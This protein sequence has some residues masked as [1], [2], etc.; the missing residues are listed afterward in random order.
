MRD[1]PTR[2]LLLLGVSGLAI[3]PVGLAL[4]SRLRSA[5]PLSVG[6]FVDI[7]R[8][9][10]PAA[11]RQL[12]TSGYDVTG[13]GGAIYVPD[14]DQR[15]QEASSWRVRDPAGRW[16]VL[17]E[18]Q[19]T[20]E[21]FGARGRS[22]DASRDR[23][24]MQAA[25]LFASRLG[26]P[27]VHAA[28]Q[29]TYETDGEV[30][31]GRGVA[32]ILNG[33]TVRAV[34][35]HPDHAALSVLSDSSWKQGRVTVVSTGVP[36]AQAGCHA[37]VR[38]GPV[39]GASSS[40]AAVDP[41][42][43]VSGWL[44]EDLVIETDAWS[45]ETRA[46]KVAVQI[47]GGASGWTVR[48]V[49]APDSTRMWGLIH[50]DWASVGPV[51]SAD[52]RQGPNRAAYQARPRRG[53]TTHPRNGLIEDCHGGRFTARVTGTDTG[54]DGIRLSACHDITVRGCTMKATTYAGLRIVGGD[55]GFEFAD[56]ASRAR[57]HKGLVVEGFEV[58]DARGGYACWVD[59]KA[60]NV[61]RAVR[62][63]GYVPMVPT[64]PETDLLVS[65]L[66]G[67]TSSGAT[68]G[69]RLNNMRG[70]EFA[71]C[72][73]QGFTDGVQVDEGVHDVR[74]TRPVTLDSH[75]HGGVVDH[76]GARPSGIV[77]QDPVA[78]RSGTRS[79]GAHWLFGHCD[80]CEISGGELGAARGETASWGIVL[81]AS[82][83]NNVLRGTPR[84]TVR[85]GGTAILRS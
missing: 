79:N 14:S 60:D 43:G 84:I 32:N 38:A 12:Q 55:L 67:A 41:Q 15:L 56:A 17:A 82:G 2:R 19:P 9:S 76:A 13:R 73:V 10:V 52:A 16:W 72:V 27:E 63:G 48:R 83:R 71:D 74:L 53:W 40:P 29:V 59:L 65:R 23:R 62:G 45:R 80:D 70:G 22:A 7:P 49:S 8:L 69:L 1:I 18:P 21:M 75:R 26:L 35:S 3:V 47:N 28:H 34:L 51:V 57:A 6:L 11:T 64:L 66:K 31:A 61:E 24:A 85:S 58:A 54:S 68:S 5:P 33:S 42:E 20:Y 50:A 77:V 44:L 37:G 81:N 25:N 39:L 46:G 4:N 30:Q 36:G 78:Q